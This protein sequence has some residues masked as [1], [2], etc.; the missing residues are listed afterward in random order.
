LL[1]IHNAI[2]FRD[3]MRPFLDFI[4]Q[5]PEFDSLIVSVT[6]DDGF[7]VSYRRRA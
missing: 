3:A 5:H 6:M 4:R 2:R 7:S 1:V